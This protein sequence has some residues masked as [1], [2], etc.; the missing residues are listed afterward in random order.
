[1]TNLVASDHVVV[2]GAGLAGWR[3]VES[4]RREGFDGAITLVGDEGHAPYDRPPLSKQVLAGK[5]SS[6]HTEL[7]T[8]EQL[9]RA[10]I[11]F[12]R[13]VAAT[14]LEVAST[15]V[16][17]ADGSEVRGSHVAIATGSRA[18]VLPFHAAQRLHTLRTR[19]DVESLN[20]QV[21]TLAPSTT[22][23]IIGGGFLG[24]EV[25][26]SLQARGLRPVVLEVGPRPL[27]G[28][29][30]PRVARWLEGLAAAAGI[31]LR[32]DQS[33]R[34][35]DSAGE[36][37]RV[38]LSDGTELMVGAVVVTAGAQ[39]NVEWLETSG[40]ALDNGVV[41]DRH[42]VATD[43]V[44]ALGD[45][46]R[47]EWS[48]VTG[49]ESVRV[50]HWQVA[51]EHAQRLARYWVKGEVTSDPLIPYFWS[52]QYGKKIQLLGRPHLDDDVERVSTSP[53]GS[54]WLGLYSRDGTVTGAV[55]LSNPRGL[56]LCRTFLESPTDLDEARRLAPWSH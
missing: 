33:I 16:L 8:P 9:D 34:D 7:A 54:K 2:V 14:A 55:T 43:R 1:M 26:T 48:S 5:W 15:T 20:A 44:G 37:F 51:A 3:F 13:G 27:E 19:E 45:V 36:G 32:N 35:V 56:M 30:G 11:V 40:L 4:L 47:F 39:C 42:L 23:A 12:R 52:D 28:V 41:V 49:S 25:A 22:V 31:E 24:A 21:A 29:L 10:R 18:R 38:A 50:E 6:E 53:D 17:L 46:A